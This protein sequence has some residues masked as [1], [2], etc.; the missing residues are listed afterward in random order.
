MAGNA[1]T[2]TESDP[3]GSADDGSTDTG[4][5]VTAQSVTPLARGVLVVAAGVVA[6]LVAF[7]SRYGYHRDELYF[8]AA[9][10]RLAWSYDDQGP[11]TP[12][13]ARAMA[14]IAPGSLTVLRLPSALA[15]GLT[16]L[17]TGLLARELGARG[18]GQL[19][20]AT[21]AAVAV[22]VLFTGHTLSTA[23]FDLLVWTA[24]TW[25]V[26]RAHRTGDDRLWLLVGTV[27]GVGLLNKPLPA[28]L[29]A[30][31]VVT[32]GV[33][34]PRRSLASGYLWTGAVIM[35]VLWSPWLVWQ[36]GHGWPQLAVSRSIAAGNSASS[37]PWWQILP[38]QA[39]LAGPLL[40]PVWI[41]GLAR[42][43]RD[44]ALRRLRFLAWTYLL[45]AVV[46]MAT[47]GKSYYLAG[48]LP[49]LIAA[50]AVPVDAWLD[51]GR[52]YVRRAA[53][54]V[55][56]A[57]SA[58]AG[59]LIGLPVLPASDAGPIIAMNADVGE[60]I[61]WPDLVRTVA[62]VARQVPPGRGSPVILTRNYGEAGA[63][64]RYG[65]A[66]GLP[67]AYSGHNAFGDWGPPPDRDGP[68]V[69]IGFRPSSAAPFLRGCRVAAYVDNAAGIDNDERGKPV[70]LCDGPV[71]PW[72]QEW[73]SLRHLG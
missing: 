37:Q 60:T 39:L 2:S 59:L 3:H 57:L 44:P 27:L 66:L 47:G 21:T 30:G 16:V 52:P 1:L 51:R 17:I 62:E 11:L 5:T 55:V 18:R 6:A 38:F 65:P 7:A 9:G 23:T 4:P 34:G 73:P 31:L 53:T 49:V 61:G 20:A 63:I 41:V 72:S 70:L 28:F 48:L 26:V 12:L 58:V 43:L 71:R 14:G 22:I 64:D 56:V 24:A 8:L 69:A 54:A 25:L 50:G 13:V 29:A 67:A 36:A 33:M 10:H 42:L 35:I 40:A 45:L 68:V 19:L 46:F 15:A 32:I